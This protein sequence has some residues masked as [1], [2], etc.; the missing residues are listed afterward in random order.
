[1]L[2]CDFVEDNGTFCVSGAQRYRDLYFPLSSEYGLK[3]AVTPNLGGDAKLDQNHFLYEPVS[4]CDLKNNRFARNFWVAPVDE[5]GQAAGEIWSAVGASAAQRAALYTPMEEELTV[6]AGYMWHETKL[7][8]KLLPVES[9]VTSF[10]PMDKN[11]EIH[12]VTLTNN[13]D[14]TLRFKAYAALPLYG[15]SA[16]NIRDHRHVTSLLHRISAGKGVVEVNPT[17]SFDERGH[18]VNDTRY[19]ATVKSE[20]T[21]ITGYFVDQE[22]FAGC[23][24]LERPE[25]VLLRE[26]GEKEWYALD[27]QE[28]M[29]GFSFEAESLA[30]YSST[31]YIM[32]VGACY[33]REELNR[34]VEDYPDLDAVERELERTKHY[35]LNKVN[36]KFHTS[37][38]AF[39]NY[40]NWVCFQP[41]LRRLFGCSFLPHHDYGKG[42]RGWRDLWQD[43]LAL[44]LMNPG[45]V[46]QMLLSN[47]AGVRMDGTNAT[48]IGEHLGEF[49]ADRNSITR[50]WMDHGVWPAKTTKLYIDQ[51]GDLDI[52][53]QEVKYFKD[54]QVLRGLGVDELWN[55]EE[56]WQ[57]DEHGREYTGTV[58]EHMLLQNLTAFWEVG[59]HN[60]IRLRD[61]DWN[62]ALD[63]A[64]KRGESVAF[65]NAYAQNLSELAELV[66]LFG[67][68][69][70]EITLLQ[71]AMILLKDESALYEDVSAKNQLLKEYGEAVKHSVSG[72]KVPVKA[73]ELAKSLRNK[74]EWIKEHIRKTE[75]I[76]DQ[77][78]EGGWFN[79]YYDNDG[80]ALESVENGKANMLLTGQVFAIMAKTA[81]DEQ[82]AKICKAA[83]AY[84]YDAN[85]GGYRLNTNFGEVKTNM[86][87]MFGFAF[88]EKENGAVFSHMAVMYANALYTRGF[89]K[90]GYKSLATLYRQSM[91]FSQSHIYPGVPEYFGRGGKGL[92]HYLTGAASWYMLTV[93]NEMFGVR[94][95]LGNLE[96]S[97]NL[98][99]EQFDSEGNAGISLKFAGHSWQIRYEN[100]SLK[101]VGEY[102]VKQ[103]SVDGCEIAVAED[104][105]LCIPLE[106]IAKMDNNRIHKVIVS[107]A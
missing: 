40:M 6:T 22:S 65:S 14:K 66:E 93:M 64:G 79:G 97:P 59:E 31:S 99:A 100:P 13:S 101:E 56:N 82:V 3:S 61:A 23:G 49:K 25:A 11:L 5:E 46:R 80:N 41:E 7:E 2:K 4:S 38:K 20:N 103:A 57:N 35:W 85:C 50:V 95:T 34:M 89:C 68:R 52:L 51:T 21:E 81:S 94:G 1:M 29:G 96:I 28:A 44:L 19:F 32:M 105:K 45:N 74:S 69:G 107:L 78:S 16:D 73:S 90:E 33:T 77:S 55:P 9:K 84:L 67:A 47:Y 70:E 42:G 18:Q 72:M 54:R 36:V 71:E 27:G 8:G 106:T 39:D 62:D 87:R 102:Q 104:H 12:V 91:N 26:D 86:G 98:L 53:K 43:C 63:M 17:L 75:W 88:G 24:D 92:Y 48:I 83:D 37:D 60:H 10:V 58:L 30:P 76:A 15:R